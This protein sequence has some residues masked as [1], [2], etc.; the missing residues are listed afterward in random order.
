MFVRTNHDN[1][2]GISTEDRRFLKIMEDGMKKNEKGSWE[3]PL[4][5]RHD[6][7]DLPSSRVN[8][9][10]RLTS[11]R[12]TLDK[13]PVMKE[14]YFTFMQ[15]IFDNDHAEIVPQEDL[16]PDKLCWYLPHFG[17]YH[18]KKKDKIRV[19]FDSAAESNGVSLNKLLLSGPDLTN[20]LLGV[21]LRFCQDPVALVGDI[22]QM[23]H[24]FNVKEEFRDFLRFLWYKDNDPNGAITEY[25]MKVHIFGNTSSPAVANYA[26]RKTA[27]V[28][29][30]KFGSDAKS[31]VD[32]NFYVDDALHSAPDS[33]TAIDFLRRTQAML[34]TANLRLHKIA[35]SHAE[36]ME[37]FPSEDHASGLHN[38]DFNKG[39]VPMQRSLGVYWDLQSDS[40]TFQVLLEEKPFTR[41]GVLSVT[42]SLY[43]PLGLAAPVIIKG[44]HLLRSL[45]KEF[46][47]SHPDAWDY[48]LPAEREAEWKEWCHSLRALEDIKVPRSYR[49]EALKCSSRI[50]LHTFCDASEMAI[51]AVSYLRIVHN[52]CQVQ[53]AFVLGKAKLTPAHAATI[54]RLELCASVLGV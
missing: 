50:E 46:S 15:K 35:S 48:P 36:V 11:T 53:V 18:P 25:R 7:K 2:P 32:N 34:A 20:N 8:A 42:N 51:S 30:A 23:F 3:A 45:S 19:A 9:M 43:D 28:G 5:F 16:R 31:F 37:A 1:K 27:E 52:T 21:L 17:V 49:T 13:N 10:K 22:E 54:P 39:P 26:L 33:T 4:P 29:E 44:K 14:Q 12:R 38:L 40:F 41:R 47:A 24:S 6:V